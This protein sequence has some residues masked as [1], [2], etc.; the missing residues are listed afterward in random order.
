MS[1]KEIVYSNLIRLLGNLSIDSQKS[2]EYY[3]LIDQEDEVKQN[4]F[5]E[6]SETIKSEITEI[7]KSRDNN[8]LHDDFET[9][10]RTLNDFYDSFND[11]PSHRISEIQ[12]II[13]L[14]QKFGESEEAIA[15]NFDI[16]QAVTNDMFSLNELE[17]NIKSD[18][19]LYKDED[20]FS[21]SFLLFNPNLP[22]KFKEYFE[23]NIIP[24]DLIIALLSEVGNV[25]NSLDG[26]TYVLFKNDI[27][28]SSNIYN[29]ICYQLVK[30]GQIFHEEY[31]YLLAPNLGSQRDSKPENQYQ[32]FGDT[33]LILS[34]YNAEKNL[35]D[36]YLR[37]YQV[38][39]NFM[40][41]S[42]IVELERKHGGKMFTIREFQRLYKRVDNS[43]LKM[44]KKIIDKVFSLE[45][46]DG[47]DFKN[48]ISNNWEALVNGIPGQDKT[49]F[50]TLLD[51]AGFA[52]NVKYDQF[53][54]QLNQNFTKIIYFLR[55]SIVHNKETEFHITHNELMN[56]E[57]I[58]DAVKIL[59]EKFMIPSLERIVFQLLENEND[60][61]WYENSTL[62]LFED[63]QTQ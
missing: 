33:L 11:F 27:T 35:L 51:I 9:L 60:I 58:D 50:D 53:T 54:N 46:G 14:I 32:Q 23:S 39:E 10:I 52:E 40:F 19:Y 41:R 3:D 34:E 57:I 6:L 30:E 45:N 63:G 31:S 24:P 18:F 56:H 5:T 38:L 21:N 17:K 13:Q 49:K 62:T 59:L 1:L 25:D 48:Y 7:D 37:L 28:N 29:F 8:E 15:D 26:N 16:N 43:E 20:E 44:L 42:P 22:Q 2:E 55:N 61:I 12:L 36:K 47:T 4:L